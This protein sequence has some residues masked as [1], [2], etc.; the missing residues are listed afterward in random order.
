V[1]RGVEESVNGIRS[2]GRSVFFAL[3]PPPE[4]T[5][6]EYESKQGAENIKDSEALLFSFVESRDSFS[7]RYGF[8]E[9]L[10]FG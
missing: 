8:A 9:G 7:K 1:E 6:A 3:G 4:V 5:L 10:K 2:K